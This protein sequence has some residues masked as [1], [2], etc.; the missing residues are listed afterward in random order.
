M[1]YHIELLKN[2]LDYID[3]YEEER[4]NASLE[5]FSVFLKDKVFDPKKYK[6]AG[7]FSNEDYK[8]YR[9]YAEVEFSIGLTT[10]F[11]FAKIYIKKAFADSS[12]KTLD[13]F[14]FLATLMRE[15]SLLK[16]ELIQKH[17]LEVSSGSEILKRLIKQGLIYEFDDE[18]DRRAKRVALTE[19]GKK[20]ILTAFNQ[21][22]KVSEII[23]GNLTDEELKNTLAVFQKLTSFHWRLHEEDKNTAL[24][25][26]Y[27]KYIESE[28]S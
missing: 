8:N 24:D 4:G 18:H 21:M 14:G 6:K 11:R 25:E 26:L 22:H 17:L 27:S 16:G 20:E 5:E 9:K 19:L 15:K 3:L 1:S 23:I 28:K 10:L 2:L 12:F 13:E 7:S